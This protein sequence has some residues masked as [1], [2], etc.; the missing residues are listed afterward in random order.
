MVISFKVDE[1][2]KKAMQR[3][4]EEDHRN[5]S[6]YIVA[7]FIRHLEEKGVDWR[8]EGEEKPSK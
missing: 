6:N 8:K 1:R 2:I 7:L 3:L 5:L 4:A